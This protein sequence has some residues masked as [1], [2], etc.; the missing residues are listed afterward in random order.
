MT[1][2]DVANPDCCD[3]TFVLLSASLLKTV[4]LH[5]A[6]VCPSGRLGAQIA[7]PR[8]KWFC[9]RNISYVK[10]FQ[11]AALQLQRL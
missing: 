6:A 3:I 5:Q 9:T 7:S 8:S 11:A 1:A 10:G 2:I 4:V